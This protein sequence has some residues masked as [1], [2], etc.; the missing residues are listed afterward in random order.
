MKGFITLARA[1]LRPVLEC[2]FYAAQNIHKV[3][4]TGSVR[5]SYVDQYQSTNMHISIF[6]WTKSMSD[7]VAVA[8]ILIGQRPN[9]NVTHLI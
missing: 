8:H 1:D 5:H 3:S 6:C 7:K 9:S 2:P 4:Q